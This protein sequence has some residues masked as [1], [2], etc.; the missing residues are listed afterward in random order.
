MQK[1]NKT[2]LSPIH[3]SPREA[4]YDGVQCDLENLQCIEDHIAKHIAPVSWVWGE[5]AS[6]L[7]HLDVLIIE[8][9]KERPCYTLVTS[10]M[11]QKPMTPPRPEV[12][13]A[14]YSELVLHLPPDWP[15]HDPELRKSENFWPIELIK[16]VARFPHVFETWL[17]WT[18]TVHNEKPYHP[19]V[20]FAGVMLIQDTPY[21]QDFLVMETDREEP[22][23]FHSL[24]LL[25]QAELD[26]YIQHGYLAVMD[27]LTKQGHEFVI[28]PDRPSAV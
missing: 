1:K 18:Q 19:S 23:V 25:H 9:S 7:I 15:M 14:K 27:A 10:G 6:S 12:A 4:K 13:K 2:A 11:S 16:H 26:Y 5:I 28:D 20:P 8:P 21:D 17:W 22:T 3:Y 24:V